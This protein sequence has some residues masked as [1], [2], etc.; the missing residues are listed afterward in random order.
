MYKELYKQNLSNAEDLQESRRKSILAEQKQNRA[1]LQDKQRDM[2]SIVAV[3]TNAV[4]TKTNRKFKQ[5]NFADI[6]GSQYALSLS[7]WLRERPEQ[8]SDW[9]LVPCPKGQRCMVVACNGRTEMFNK[10]GRWQLRFRSALPGDGGG[11]HVLTILDCVFAKHLNTFYVLDALA[12]GNQDLLECEAQFRFFWLRSKFEE[13][14]LGDTIRGKNDKRFVLLAQHDFENTIS[15]SVA[16]QRYP[17]WPDNVP[18]LDGFLFYH[19]EANYTCGTTPLIGWLFPFMVPELLEYKVSEEYLKPLNFVNN[20]Q[21]IDEF[22][23]KLKQKKHKRQMSTDEVELMD[24]TQI[25]DN[26]ESELQ[27]LLQAER[28]LELGIEVN[29]EEQESIQ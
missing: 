17:Y 25:E 11:R 5:R 19:K 20:Q 16:L 12:F 6:Y 21:F 29:L 7:E 28:N 24:A 27:H 1:L 18:E 9:S 26:D 4:K 23:A 13:F 2:E 15:V 3:A 10:A 14:E 22:D 8:L